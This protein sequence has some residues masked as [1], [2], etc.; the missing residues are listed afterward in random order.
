[1]H[2]LFLFPFFLEYLKNVEYSETSVIIS[3][4]T[5]ESER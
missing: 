5:V 2:C 1:M 4:E 3:E